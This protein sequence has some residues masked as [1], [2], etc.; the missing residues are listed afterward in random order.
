[1][2]QWEY[3]TQF[4]W[5]DIEEPGV[6]ELLARN[7]S[8]WN[9]QR[10]YIPQAIIPFLSDRGLEGWELVHMQPVIVGSRYDVMVHSVNSFGHQEW[11]NTYFCAFKRRLPG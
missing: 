8:D 10:R 2:E 6:S 11:T 5:A 4:V 3:Q 7:Y 1:M 9:N